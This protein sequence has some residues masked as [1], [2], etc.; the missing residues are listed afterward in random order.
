MEAALA[1]ELEDQSPVKDNPEDE[2]Q[3]EQLPISE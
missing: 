2:T 1:A 3:I